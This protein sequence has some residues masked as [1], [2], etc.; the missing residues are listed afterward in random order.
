MF[1][2]GDPEEVPFLLLEIDSPII[3]D[4]KRKVELNDYLRNRLISVKWDQELQKTP[5]L[6]ITLANTDLFWI[7][8]RPIGGADLLVEGASVKWQMGYFMANTPKITR[9]TIPAQYTITGKPS[10]NKDT[11]TLKAETALFTILGTT[12]LPS[13]E[14]NIRAD[15]VIHR[16]CDAVGVDPE[17]RM[18]QSTGV[19]VPNIAIRA[20][21]TVLQFIYRL[22]SDYN[23]VVYTT[24]APDQKPILHFHKPGWVPSDITDV[25][26]EDVKNVRETASGR[27][28]VDPADLAESSTNRAG[29]NLL[30][31]ELA[32]SNIESENYVPTAADNDVEELG[33]S[34]FL[35]GVIRYRP[36][37]P[38]NSDIIDFSISH[39]PKGTPATAT[40]N[41]VDPNTG[42]VIN[43]T[44]TE[45]DLKS[46]SLSDTNIIK[47]MILKV[48]KVE[49]AFGSKISP[50]DLS[51][52]V[53]GPKKG[54]PFQPTDGEPVTVTPDKA[55]L[56]VEYA[57]V[58]HSGRVRILGMGMDETTAKMKAANA[59]EAGAL[60]VV[61]ISFTFRGKPEIE[62]GQIWGVENLRMY[63]NNYLISHVSHE[64]SSA[65]FVTRTNMSTDGVK[66]GIAVRTDRYQKKKYSEYVSYDKTPGRSRVRNLITELGT[67]PI[68]PESFIDP[69]GRR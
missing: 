65:G 1:D 52:I 54:I 28:T 40:A 51:D 41:G 4:V 42:K 43:V 56:Y 46:F 33:N 53:G 27:N 30:L 18:I 24:Q 45:E 63:S 17:H 15:K 20:N 34:D 66:E 23:Y 62:V 5:V 14:G 64:F 11:Y 25:V 47:A 38:Y 59:I 19:I 8:N 22:A 32:L 37:P 29:K 13:W 6:T 7:D 69:E 26:L 68:G 12:S 67:T 49:A 57:K 21:E 48:D 39:D 31:L 44:A 16:I 60:G 50:A 58:A 10:I 61:K 36:D 2:V 35:S 55:N 3:Q 9:A